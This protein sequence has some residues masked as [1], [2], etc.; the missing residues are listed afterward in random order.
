L[1]DGDG[2]VG[3]AEVTGREVPSMR[4]TSAGTLEVGD[5]EVG[6]AAVAEGGRCLQ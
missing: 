6:G 5:G 3:G 2:E 4:S 1:D